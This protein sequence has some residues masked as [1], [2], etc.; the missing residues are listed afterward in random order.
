MNK[1]TIKKK[2][3]QENKQIFIHRN[4]TVNLKKKNKQTNKTK[5]TNKQTKNQQVMNRKVQK[6]FSNSEFK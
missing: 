4:W 5:Q 2:K 1:Q 3:K 6:F